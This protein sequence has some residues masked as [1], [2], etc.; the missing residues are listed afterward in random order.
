VPDD[1]SAEAARE[2]WIWVPPEPP[3]GAKVETPPTAAQPR[4]QRGSV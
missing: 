1:F 3:G 2:G 4:R